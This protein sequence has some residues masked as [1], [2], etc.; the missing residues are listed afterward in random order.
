MIPPQTVY[1]FHQTVLLLVFLIVISAVPLISGFAQTST[2]IAATKSV[3][4]N[5]KPK[6]SPVDCLSA[7]YPDRRRIIIAEVINS[8]AIEI[9]K[10]QY[11]A[12]AEAKKITGDVTARILVDALGK[13]IW[14]RIKDGHPLL[15]KAVG[16]VVC[17]AVFKPAVI[18]RIPYSVNGT[19]TY[20]F[21][22]P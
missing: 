11:P 14:A 21:G 10:P 12:R 8:K 5:Q 19:I 16:K 18:S 6:N 9:P 2:R 7:E 15:Q 13:V 22:L 4:R 3:K 17:K 1:A 20:R